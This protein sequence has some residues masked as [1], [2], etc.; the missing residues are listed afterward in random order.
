MR[1]F[2]FPLC[3]SFLTSAFLSPAIVQRQKTK[4]QTW[5][6]LYCVA[7]SCYY[8]KYRTICLNFWNAFECDTFEFKD[9][10]VPVLARYHFGSYNLMNIIRTFSLIFK[11]TIV[12]ANFF[13]T[14]NYIVY[15][16]LYVEIF[17]SCL[18]ASPFAVSPLRFSYTILHSNSYTEFNTGIFLAIKH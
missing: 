11:I 13:N 16:L 2:Y 1:C 4:L 5:P 8:S 18:V 7:I 9:L 3:L 6:L 14:H 15:F 12:Y 17:Y 10:R